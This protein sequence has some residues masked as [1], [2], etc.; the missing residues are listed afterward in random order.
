MLCTFVLVL[1][2]PSIQSLNLPVSAPIK[3]CDTKPQWPRI[4][5]SGA[6]ASELLVVFVTSDQFCWLAEA[7]VLVVQQKDVKNFLLASLQ[8]WIVEWQK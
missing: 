7:P 5:T 3:V 4:R 8:S 2:G 1:H 6:Y